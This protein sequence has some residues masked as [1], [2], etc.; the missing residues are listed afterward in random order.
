ME[1]EDDKSSSD[2]VLSNDEFA[3]ESNLQLVYKEFGVD[4]PL[5]K[6]GDSRYMPIPLCSLPLATL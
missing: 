3:T 6:L 2:G 5:T 4:A 1:E